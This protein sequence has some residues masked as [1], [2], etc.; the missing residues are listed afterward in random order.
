MSVFSNL[1][2]PK[3]CA[4]R[5]KTSG[6]FGRRTVTSHSNGVALTMDGNLHYRRSHR[7][8]N[9]KPGPR[10]LQNAIKDSAATPPK[11]AKIMA[12]KMQEMA[13]LTA[14][15]RS[16]CHCESRLFWDGN[17]GMVVLTMRLSRRYAP[18]NDREHL[19]HTQKV[20]KL[21]RGF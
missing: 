11:N 5:V 12:G 10:K 19:C 15:L 6:R 1:N 3:T 20:S 17:P 16:N 8:R 9:V 4:T 14:C 13:D 2:N 7:R 21:N 18:R